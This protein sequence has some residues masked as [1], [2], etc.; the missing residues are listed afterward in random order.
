M[1]RTLIRAIVTGA[2]DGAREAV[3]EA[4]PRLYHPRYTPK[5]RDLIRVRHEIAA[6][7]LGRLIRELSA[8]FQDGSGT[9][10]ERSPR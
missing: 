10:T 5:D 7:R 9:V 4:T 3:E 6:D 1:I 2:I 8:S